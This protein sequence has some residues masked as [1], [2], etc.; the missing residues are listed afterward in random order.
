MNSKGQ[1]VQ[2]ESQGREETA[3]PDLYAALESAIETIRIWHGMRFVGRSADDP[4]RD[5]EKRAWEIYRTHAPEMKRLYAALAKA[6]DEGI[7]VEKPS[8]DLSKA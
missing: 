5:I 1:M 4:N 8:D 6:R 3:T 7:G 2:T